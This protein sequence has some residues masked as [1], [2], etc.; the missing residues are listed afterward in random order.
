MLA[1]SARARS[2]AIPIAGK[3][4]RNVAMMTR[5]PTALRSMPLE[6]ACGTCGLSPR[7]PGD[8]SLLVAGCRKDQTRTHS[9]VASDSMGLFDK[10]LGSGDTTKLTEAEG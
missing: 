2:V 6:S 5:D 3:T 10:V 4:R 8:K 1:E 9:V 7:S